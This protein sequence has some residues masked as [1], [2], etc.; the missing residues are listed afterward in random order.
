M[1][2][3]DYLTRNEQ[4][5]QDQQMTVCF[6][7][8]TRRQ[9][10]ERGQKPLLALVTCADSRVIP[11]VVFNAQLG[12]ILVGRNAGNTISEAEYAT[13][14]YGVFSLGITEIV[15]LGHSGCG[16]VTAAV[17]G[18]TDPYLQ[19]VLDRIREGVRAE[20]SLETTADITA[21]EAIRLNIL[22]QVK[23]LETHA[24]LEQLCKIGQLRVTGLYYDQHTG[25]LQKLN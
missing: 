5:V 3:E 10:A 11:E 14:H 4:L 6:R 2:L 22:H 21:D 19:T 8:E 12:E 25:L 17:S 13:I 15:V 1:I 20:S 18:E 24:A 7:P 23:V 16:A 9:L